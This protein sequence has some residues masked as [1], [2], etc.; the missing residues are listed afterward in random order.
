MPTAG[1]E[2]GNFNCKSGVLWRV[3]S[4]ALVLDAYWNP[5][6]FWNIEPH[7]RIVNNIFCI[8]YLLVAHLWVTCTLTIYSSFITSTLA[9][10]ANQSNFLTIHILFS[11]FWKFIS[12]SLFIMLSCYFFITMFLLVSYLILINCILCFCSEDPTISNWSEWSK[13]PISESLQ[14]AVENFS[15]VL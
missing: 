10:A 13:I 6:V 12:I 14:T 4:K 3:E 9:C 11:I 5:K 2:C 15:H 8:L 7:L 1:D